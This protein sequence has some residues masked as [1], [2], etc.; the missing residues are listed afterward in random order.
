MFFQQIPGRSDIKNYLQQTIRQ[1][2]VPHAQL[3]WGPEGSGAL[4]LAMAFATELMCEQ[5]GPEGA[6]GSCPS[7]R[8]NAHWAH[9]DVHISFPT[10]G[11]QTKS[12]DVIQVW[13]DGFQ[14]QP[15][16]TMADWFALQEADNKQ[17]GINKDECLH[18]LR[19]LQ[20][21]SFEA[22]KK[23][24]IIWGAE[25]L[26]KEGNRLLK[27]IEE[28]TPDTY[29]ILIADELQDLLPTIVSRCQLLKLKP[30]P[31]TEIRDHL[32]A[33]YQMAP[34]EA[35]QIAHYA[36][37][38]MH[39]AIQLA[40]E[41]VRQQAPLLWLPWF[42]YCLQGRTAQIVELNGSIE[43]LGR[44]KV[45]QW[46]QFGLGFLRTLLL[47]RKGVDITSSL[48]D[49]GQKLIQFGMQGL[50]EDTIIRMMEDISD[51]ESQVERNG[52]IRLLLLARYVRWREWINLQR[53]VKAA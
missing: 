14:K 15:F 32:V 36:Q 1:H 16:I 53:S 12:A 7:C 24:W 30:Y 20:M 22:A 39:H 40:S 33:S 4:P 29:M 10:I 23:I 41:D 37:G 42:Q 18:M 8:K 5:P 26:G 21:K 50:T 13:R 43:Q 35:L 52:Q 48:S 27:M 44:E 45:K 3:F 11:A 31:E 49:A 25:Y 51:L 38:D 9:P 47:L 28:P 19:T 2:R 34:D 46:V 17:G 6:C